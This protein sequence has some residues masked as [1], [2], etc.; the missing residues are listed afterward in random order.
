MSPK[1]NAPQ[2]RAQR[3]STGKA[4][5][6]KPSLRKQQESFPA[7][8]TTLQSYAGASQPRSRKRPSANNTGKK[9]PKAKRITKKR[10]V[11]FFVALLL[12][13]VG[14]LGWKFAFNIARLFGGNPFSVLTS[15]KLDGE[16]TGRVNILLAGNSADDP[17]HQG[18]ALTD[19]IMV[20]SIDVEHNTAF[21]MSV[22][23]D[24][25]VESASGDYT[26]INAIYPS[27]ESEQFS[28]DG[29]FPGGMGRLQQVIQDNFGL[30]LH[31]YALVNYNALK[32]AVDSVG[33]IQFTVE[34]SNSRGLYDPNTDW[35]TGGPLVKLSNGTHT[36]NGQEALN[37]A[38]ARGDS[39]RAY[40]FP[41]GD[42]DR[43]ENQRK[44]ILALRQKATSAGVLANP[45]KLGSL[46]DAIGANVETNFNLGDVR[47]LYDITNKIPGGEIRSVGLNDADGENLL[48]NYRTYNGQSALIPAA[49]VDDYSDI[50][51]FLRRLTS[52]NL[53]V[54]ENAEV[55]VLNGT[56]RVGL[57]AKDAD[58]LR[59]KNVRVTRIAD[60]D[61]ED[62]TVT[63]IIN[64]SGNTKQN[65]L[66]LLK[67]HFEG[68]KV[69]TDN[70]YAEKYDTADFIVVLGKDR[71]T[72]SE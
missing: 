18:A 9:Q 71:P 70:S 48:A 32:D 24:L 44:I 62:Y 59:N 17:G 30:Q 21:M 38:R 52:N 67:K 7:M 11:L 6:I 10:I 58:L 14:W 47:R 23:R 12:I 22:P 1:Q 60:A 50:Q 8:G 16:S 69:V 68:S 35:T 53:I 42:F 31:Y 4:F 25:Y 55:V 39:S 36:L 34:S 5:D 57:A 65:T 41:R 45:V 43:T 49:G 29:Y 63:E 64:L 2:R 72:T 66:A 28:R 61:T 51:R 46:F 19:S 40:G 56:E 27:G 15:S 13:A 3:T 20:A 26:K 33:G 37:L 54:R